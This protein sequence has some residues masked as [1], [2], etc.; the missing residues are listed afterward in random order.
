MIKAA[1]FLVNEWQEAGYG[2]IIGRKTY[3]TL[4]GPVRINRISHGY[5]S[6]SQDNLTGY[7]Y[8]K[9]LRKL[10]PKPTKNRDIGY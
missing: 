3:Y 7:A 6:P 2:A 10:Q 5:L 9:P 1:K 8:P 4:M